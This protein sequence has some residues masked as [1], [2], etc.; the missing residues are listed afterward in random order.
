MTPERRDRVERVCSEALECEPSA[1]GAYL[2][3]ACAGDEDLR[4]EVESLLAREARANGF[5]DSSPYVVDAATVNRVLQPGVRLGPY[6]V[7]EQI[8]AGGM[9]EVYRA[10]DTN[11]GRDV[12]IKVLPEAFAQDPE[13][14]ARFER[15]AKTLASLN[16]PNIAIIHGLER[17]GDG[18]LAIVMELVEGPTLADRIAQGPIPVDEALPIAKQIAEALEAAHEQG[19][20]HRDLK[21]ANIKLR[22]DGIVRVL[23]F[24]LAKALELAPSSESMSPRITTPTMTQLGRIL[25]TAAYMSPEQAKGKPADKRSDVW[26]FGCVLYEMLTRNRAF[27]GE[28]VT[29][30]LT[31]VLRADVDWTK[32]PHLH[33]RLVEVLE[34]C[35]RKDPGRRLRDI[36]D[37]RIELDEVSDDPEGVSLH[38]SL[39][40]VPDRPFAVAW[41]GLAV[42]MSALLAIAATWYYLGATG[43]TLPVTRFV[44]DLPVNQNW[45]SNEGVGVSIS[46]D[47]RHV[48]YTATNAEGIRQL[49]L[50]PLSAYASELIA[51]SEGAYHPFFSPD[52]RQLAFFASGSIRRVAV[53]GGNPIEITRG[54]DELTRGATWAGDGYVYFGGA[55]GISRVA[56]SGGVPELVTTLGQQAGVAHRWPEAIPSH[57]A[58]LFTVFTG[59]LE[60]SRIAVLSLQTNEWKVLLDGAGYHARYAPTGHVVYLRGNRMMAVPFDVDRLEITGVPEPVLDGVAANTGGASHFRFSDNGT[61]AYVPGQVRSSKTRTIS[62]SPVWVDAKGNEEAIGPQPGLYTDPAIAPDGTRVAM[63]VADEAGSRNIRIWDLSRRNWTVLTGDPSENEVPVWTLDARRIVFSG[64]NGRFNHLYMQHADGI[65]EARRLSQDNGVTTVGSS[66]RSPRAETGWY[67]TSVSSDGRWLFLVERAGNNAVGTLPLEG[68][69][70][71]R[72]LF[73]GNE[74]RLSPNRRWLAYSSAE[75]GSSQIYVRPFPDVEATRWTVSR[76]GANGP[77]WSP[78]GQALY[79]RSGNQ[80]VRVQVADGDA[81]SFGSTETLFDTSTYL[82]GH[83]LASDGRFLMLRRTDNDASGRPHMV[84]NWFEELQRLVPTK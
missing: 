49:Y 27:D 72:R 11:L 10:K 48:A 80:M 13:R 18:V 29:D 52:S 5:L 62:S 20:I 19:I 73:E 22:P 81:F 58:L 76:G 54:I 36:G 40:G 50:R 14:L 63:T 83:D 47:G 82:R 66:E 35:L 6:L 71:P 74:A 1:R 53:T 75:S 3:E 31:A 84:L 32:L 56:A 21:P 51:R 8:G 79:Y 39:T 41:Y 28:E 46:P 23:D 57:G 37:L 38:K 24:G 34:R 69:G 44:I 12:A 61:L 15:E 16:H 45:T 25:G 26:A 4:R 70:S 2:V 30:T 43:D 42:T 65:G 9:G 59:D 77:R 67:P 55:S 78:D 17:A 64:R 60:T 7:L 33:P 68:E